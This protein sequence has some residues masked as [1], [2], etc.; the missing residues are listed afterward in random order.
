MKKVYIPNE[1]EIQQL[2][3]L[4][5]DT[6]KYLLAKTVEA[7][8]MEDIVYDEIDMMDNAYEQ[9]DEFKELTYA[10]ARIYPERIATSI[11]ARKDINLCR[12]ITSKLSR[13]DKSIYQLDA[14]SYFGD[15][16]P[17]MFDNIVIENTIKRLSEHLTSAPRYRFDYKEPNI[18][19]D[20]IFGCEIPLENIKEN[21]Q[22]ELLSV[23]PIYITKL[24]L[25]L[26]V[27]KRNYAQNKAFYLSRGLTRYAN[28]YYLENIDRT[29]QEEKSKKLIRYLDSHKENYHI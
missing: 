13:E 20:N 23:D 5:I 14:I 27:E 22:H 15:E 11:N 6:Y 21:L 16:S 1:E 29:N 8:I 3:Y 4:G 10:I 28:R 7:L 2:N 26:D 24:G 12:L 18:L 25:D 9:F 19:L 17:V